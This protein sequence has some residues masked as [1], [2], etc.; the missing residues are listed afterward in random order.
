MNNFTDLIHK[1]HD[2]FLQD[3]S[4]ISEIANVTESEYAHNLGTSNDGIDTSTALDVF[5]NNL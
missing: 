4:G 2:L 5:G 3:F 1:D